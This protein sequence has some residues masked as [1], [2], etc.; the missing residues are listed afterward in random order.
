MKR[1]RVV[2][3]LPEWAAAAIEAAPM[4]VDLCGATV[5]ERLAF[6]AVEYADAEISRVQ[7]VA[8]RRERKTLY[9]KLGL[10]PPSNPY[11]DEDE[12]DNIPF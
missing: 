5:A 12:D 2:V 7:G 3:D 1:V 4:P 10:P 11:E 9:K 6:L 8:K